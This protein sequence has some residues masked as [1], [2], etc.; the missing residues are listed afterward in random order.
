MTSGDHNNRNKNKRDRSIFDAVSFLDTQDSKAEKNKRLQT[1]KDELR[2]AAAASQTKVFGSLMECRILLQRALQHADATNGAAVDK[3]N[4]LLVKLLEA[5]Q[6]LQP[7]AN[8]SVDY[9]K[10][11]RLDDPSL[12]QTQ[13]QQDYDSCRDGWKETLN[14]RHK[15]VRL[16]AGL[17]AK[18]Q[19]KVIDSSF[20]QQVDATVQHD[21]LRSS[22]TAKDGIFD[23]TKVYQHLL[24]DFVL[25][26]NQSD[27]Q[28]PQERLK[29]T[30]NKTTSNLVD[31]KASKGR[32]IRYHEIPKLVNF[33]FPL[34]RAQS[35]TVLDENEWFSSLFGGAGTK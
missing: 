33:T 27:T 4:D 23:D 32:K 21:K 10:L 8:I 15:D 35:Q 22:G 13:L 3:C 26:A 6:Q 19:F 31:R 12:L 7:D 28:L 25:S 30:K 11:V 14:R 2:R 16:H 34:S 29:Q 17:T 5:R 18:A 1:K 9:E 24:Q 20:W